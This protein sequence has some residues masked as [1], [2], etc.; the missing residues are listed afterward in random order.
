LNNF[1]YW[2]AQIVGSLLIGIL[3]LDNP[4]FS[5]RTRA[6]LG[7]AVL[8]VLVFATHIWAYFY[9]RCALPSFAC[10]VNA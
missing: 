2:T 7:W 10:P 4:R 8:F 5:R 1:L 6:F 9:Q 3:V